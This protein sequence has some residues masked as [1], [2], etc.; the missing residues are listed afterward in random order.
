MKAINAFVGHS[1]AH[2]DA[3]VIRKFLKMLTRLS[4][5][6]PEFT[7]DHAEDPEPKQ[8]VN[9]VLEKLDGKNLFIGICT[10]K[11]R[12]VADNK[13]ARTWFSSRKLIGAADAFQWKASDWVLQE[14]GLAVG[15]GMDVL[16]LLE[17]GIRVPGEL[18][19]NPEHVVFSRDAP[20]QCFD[21]LAGMIASYVPSARL[22]VSS[23]AEGRVAKEKEANKYADATDKW[24]EPQP[25]WRID[26]YEIGMHYAIHHGNID[27]EKK[28]NDH[29]LRSPI[30]SNDALR[31]A[32]SALIVS[33][34]I[35]NSADSTI[36]DLQKLADESPTNC[37]IWCYLGSTY[38]DYGEFKQAAAAFEKAAN[39]SEDMPRRIRLLGSAMCAAA[40]AGDDDFTL[41][42]AGTIRDLNTAALS[43]ELAALDAIR[44]HAIQQNAFQLI[45]GTLERSL[46]LD[47]SD[48]E[49]RF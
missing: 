16:L 35:K 18:Q 15:R 48:D 24:S 47:P 42:I 10:K 46:E 32:W 43:S 6:R 29:F 11:E 37:D 5:L 39:N 34:K 12:V 17:D 40:K 28:I 31:G 49:K 38:S 3:D 27:A 8:I 23:N 13:L 4:D 33:L 26:D 22:T 9:K 2:E 30:A 20:E 41:R 25:G 1:F 14:I 19:G 44:E 7:W 45:L 36:A 21:S